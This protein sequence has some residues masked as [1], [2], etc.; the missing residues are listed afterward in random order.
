MTKISPINRAMPR[1]LALAIVACALPFSPSALAGQPL[2]FAGASIAEQGERNEYIGVTAPFFSSRFLTQRLAISDYYYQ[3]GTDGTTVKVRGQA[4]EVALGAQAAWQRGWVEASTGPRF[5][6]N[7][8]TPPGANARADGSQWGLA[9]GLQG[10]QRFGEDWAFNGIGS[11]TIGPASYWGR[12]RFLHRTFGDAWAGVE[13]IKHGD[14]DYRA[15]QGGLVLT[16]IKIGDKFDIGFYAGVK[17]TSGQP[18][19]FYGGI[20]LT[21]GF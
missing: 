21:K 14:P 16:G 6:H 13:V 2:I 3:Y 8:V 18:R 15:T 1:R 17:K 5:R 4:A 19:S 9:L 20:E 11:Y 10:E 7:R 12:A